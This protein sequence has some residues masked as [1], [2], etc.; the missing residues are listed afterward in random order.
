MTSAP[1]IPRCAKL[2]DLPIDELKIDRSFIIDIKP[3]TTEALIVKAIIDLGHSMG[4]KITT[5]GIETR[6][7]W[8][9]LQRLGSDTIQ[10][11]YISKPLPAADFG[12]WWLAHDAGDRS[13][14]A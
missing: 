6:E 8:D 7:E 9:L 1:A 12:P 13:L 2:R 10:G 14:A 5:E 4:M 3:D 11:Y